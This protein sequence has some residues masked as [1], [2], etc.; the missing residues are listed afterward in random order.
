MSIEQTKMPG[1]SGA[2]YNKI[3]IFIV[4][5]YTKIEIQSSNMWFLFHQKNEFLHTNKESYKKSDKFY[6]ACT[7][8]Y[9]IN[10]DMENSIPLEIVFWRTT[11]YSFFLVM[12]LLL[13]TKSYPNEITRH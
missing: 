3:H 10:F 4:T 7:F 9:D 6:A 8:N 13:T 2:H 11:R 1:K 5:L 12:G